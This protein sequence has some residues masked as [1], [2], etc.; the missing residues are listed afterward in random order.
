MKDKKNWIIALLV[1]IIIFG[2]GY[3][4]GNSKNKKEQINLVVND[5][6]TKI[7]T[8]SSSE[9]TST[10][11]NSMV[12][13]SIQESESSKPNEQEAFERMASLQGQWVVWQSD[14]N[15]TIH[16]DGTWTTRTVGPG[17]NR[18][19]SVEIH[20]YDKELDTLYVNIDG[21]ETE[22]QIVDENTLI[23]DSNSGGGTSKFIRY[24][25]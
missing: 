24:N 17:G 25:D 1:L 4:L 9:S 6:S 18:S 22:I 15:F 21:R 16:E 5:S 14:N 13:T 12:D 19:I 11:I 2:S 10:T 20:S 23:L 3:F 7:S 8:V